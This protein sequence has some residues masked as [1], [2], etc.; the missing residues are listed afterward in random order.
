[1]RSL[2]DV[3]HLT[4]PSRPCKS[5][6]RPSSCHLPT[7]GAF[8]VF[9]FLL[10]LPKRPF[11]RI[12]TCQS[13]NFSCKN[14]CRSRRTHRLLSLW[15]WLLRFESSTW[16]FVYL[17]ICDFFFCPSVKYT[18]YTTNDHRWWL[19]CRK[20]NQG[21]SLYACIVLLALLL[22]LCML[23]LPFFLF[24]LSSYCVRFRNRIPGPDRLI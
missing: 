4:R 3:L 8:L 6:R 9:H 15:P 2:L 17:F 10:F 11:V 12:N 13:E 21:V 24:L 19:K 5:W 1:M 20:S 7:A 23:L 22:L 14:L 18:R 16:L